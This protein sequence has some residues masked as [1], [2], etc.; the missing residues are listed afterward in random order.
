[1]LLTNK[2]YATLSKIADRAGEW[3]YL[4]NRDRMGLLMDLEFINDDV[5]LNFEKL[6]SFDDLNFAH[7][8]QG[9][10]NSFDRETKR[11][12]NCFVPRCAK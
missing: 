2:D 5:P 10:Y 11:L 3:I 8:I 7:D 4:S 9:I 6:L 1:M 12:K